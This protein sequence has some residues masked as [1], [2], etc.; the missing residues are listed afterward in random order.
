MA[1]SIQIFQPIVQLFTINVKLD[2]CLSDNLTY[3]S[4]R[5]YS[6][7]NIDSESSECRLD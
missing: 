7:K 3:I 2:Q 4:M 1:S 6:E 5:Q